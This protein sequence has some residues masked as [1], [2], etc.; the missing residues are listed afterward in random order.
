MFTTRRWHRYFSNSSEGVV[1]PEDVPKGS[2][3]FEDFNFEGNPS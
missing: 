2:N 1:F 3:A